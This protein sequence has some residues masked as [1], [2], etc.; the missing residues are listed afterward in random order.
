NLYRPAGLVAGVT[1]PAILFA[2]GHSH[3]AKAAPY[4]HASCLA[5]AEAGMVVLAVDPPGQGERI[6]RADHDPADEDTWGVGEHLRT[7]MSAWWLDQSLM[8]W[9]VTDLMAGV[10]LL[11]ALPEVDPQ[12]I[13][14]TGISGGG[15]QTSIMMALE[16]RLAAAAPGTY[17]T[18]RLAY[19]ATGQIQ[20]AEQHLLGGSAA[21]VDHADILA[22]FAPRPLR[23]L[24]ASWDFFAIE[25]TVESFARAQSAYAH[26]GA[27]GSLT[28][29]VDDTVHALSPG[30]RR[31]QVEF[32]CEAFG[33]AVVDRAERPLHSPGELRAT[34]SGRILDDHPDSTRITDLIAESMEGLRPPEDPAAWLRS[35]VFHDRR[36]PVLD[37]VRW[38]GTEE[39]PHLFWRA[40]AD[41]WGAAVLRDPVRRDDP[42]SPGHPASGGEPGA[43]APTPLTLVLLPEGTRTAGAAA[44]LPEEAA[45]PRIV[46]DLRGIGALSSRQRTGA[47]P[48]SLWG[49][50]YKLLSD[51][52]WI[53]DSL[54]AGRVFDLCR[55]IDV[56]TS[57]RELRRR[58][59][60]VGPGSPVE[61][62]T[63]G[64]L[65][66]WHGEL[67]ALIDPRIV[68]VRHDGAELDI[69][70]AIRTGGWDETAGNW[71][72]L[73]PGAAAILHTVGMR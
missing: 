44:L 2:S 19:Q 70:H 55:A 72:A 64:G 35:R 45:G 63:V 31:A 41:I 54:A 18:S 20:D 15:T 29:S 23:L 58:W 67:A 10:D 12:R 26:V 17:I 4:Y 6:L 9:I 24:V 25:G 14:M 48:S 33:L 43:A 11:T 28:M 13:G 3:E 50:E 51:L 39:E 52:L 8:R 53:S 37:A 46:L 22:A 61:V 27:A 71:Q 42:A 40:E 49:Y 69:A 30:L 36:R 68:R 5:L 62:V 59:P 65:A 21:G 34:R 32:F 16:P 47:P 7:G 73:I 57:D 60:G 38:V 1:V 66:R 56:L